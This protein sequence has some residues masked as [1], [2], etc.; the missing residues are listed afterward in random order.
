MET[1]GGQL[2]LSDFVIQPGL[3]PVGNSVAPIS[4]S[5]LT[6]QCFFSSVRNDVTA[7]ESRPLATGTDH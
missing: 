2:T 6:L 1:L 7:P 5:E 4:T 3:L